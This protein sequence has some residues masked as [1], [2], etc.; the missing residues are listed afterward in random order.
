M[1]LNFANHRS[2]KQ[3][4]KILTLKEMKGVLFGLKRVIIKQMIINALD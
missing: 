4:L 3:N 1:I 2:H